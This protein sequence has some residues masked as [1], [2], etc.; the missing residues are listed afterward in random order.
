MRSGCLVTDQCMKKWGKITQQKEIEDHN[1][2][3]EVIRRLVN[4]MMNS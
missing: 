1:G 3:S 4:S 2:K